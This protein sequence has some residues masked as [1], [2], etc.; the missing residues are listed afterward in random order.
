MHVAG[1]LM[2]GHLAPPAG[3]APLLEIHGR[4]DRIVPANGSHCPVTERTGAERRLLTF[5]GI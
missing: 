3:P 1:G 4:G 5:K 2:L